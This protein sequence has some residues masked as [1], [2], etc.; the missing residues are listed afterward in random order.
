MIYSGHPLSLSALPVTQLPKIENISTS[1]SMTTIETQTQSTGNVLNEGLM[2]I[3]TCFIPRRMDFWYTPSQSF[4][5]Q[6]PCIC[7][8]RYF[9][10]TI[11]NLNCPSVEYNKYI[12]LF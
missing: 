6:W 2:F 1:L 11:T 7:M 10:I 4:M 5:V 9:T 8:H 12:I 3:G